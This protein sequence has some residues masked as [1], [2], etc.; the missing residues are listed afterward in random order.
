MT[1]ASNAP[2]RWP[3]VLWSLS[4]LLVVGAV[5]GGLFLTGGP[6]YQRK[7]K[8][9]NQRINDF[10]ALRYE[11]ARYQADHKAL[12]P[13]LSDL[14][15]AYNPDI[16]KHISDPESG[17]PY[18]YRTLEGGG[19]E[20]CADFQTST[21][22]DERRRSG[23]YSPNGFPAHPAGHYCYRFTPRADRSGPDADRFEVQGAM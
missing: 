7:V 1:D 11:I 9:D 20:L 17:Q 13:A 19:F 8:M 14:T 5:A 12:P 6:G 4:C 22:E 15:G 18:V 3:A 2:S 21:R 10:S 23:Y 16:K